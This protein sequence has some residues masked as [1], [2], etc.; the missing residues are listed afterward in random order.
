[1]REPELLHQLRQ[2]RP[3]ALEIAI[4]QYGAYVA[5]VIGNILGN[6]GC[7]EDTEELAADVFYALW[8]HAGQI[9]EGKLKSW[10]GAVARN[11]T[12]DLLRK[13]RVTLP[14]DEDVLSISTD[15]PEEQAMLN[16]QKQAL[17]E[18]VHSMS[19]PDREIFLRYYYRFETMEEIA[20]RLGMP[21]G[22]VKARLHRG[23]RRLK[24]ILEEQ[25]AA[26]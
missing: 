9:E 24:N 21:L 7:L 15:S 17:L 23:R 25:E 8:E 18:A 10:L 20:L 5:T 26:L 22:T 6:V 3:R 12:K 14:M 4:D 19:E 13:R 16:M 11:R 2:H 1:M